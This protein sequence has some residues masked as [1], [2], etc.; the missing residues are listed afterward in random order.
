MSSA[1]TQDQITYQTQ[2]SHSSYIEYIPT[3][4]E[5]DLWVKFRKAEATLPYQIVDNLSDNSYL[6]NAFTTGES[7]D[8]D[9]KI[10]LIKRTHEIIVK[11]TKDIDPEMRQL[12]EDNFK[13]L[14]WT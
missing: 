12:V 3:I 11:D 6:L 10:A 4:P 8:D 2:V 9:D 13:S 7:L 5:T 14:L 1:V